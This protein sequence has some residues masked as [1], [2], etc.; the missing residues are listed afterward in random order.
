MYYGLVY[1]Q[2]ILKLKH[3]RDYS[4]RNTFKNLNV[5]Y[6]TFNLLKKLIKFI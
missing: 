5:L 2:L 1:L 6:T 4:T 3:V